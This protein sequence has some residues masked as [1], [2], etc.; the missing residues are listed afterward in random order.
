MEAFAMCDFGIAKT[1]FPFP[2]VALYGAAAGCQC[3]GGNETNGAASRFLVDEHLGLSYFIWFFEEQI[4]PAVHLSSYSIDAHAFKLQLLTISC[5]PNTF[6][7][8]VLSVPFLSISFDCG[9]DCVQR[10]GVFCR[11]L[12]QLRLKGTIL[13]HFFIYM[14]PHFSFAL[15]DPS[16]IPSE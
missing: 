4:R 12:Y 5:S 14:A 16:H 6:L 8:R 11:E 15:L 9:S 10:L 3:N 13:A 1:L 7:R 2:L